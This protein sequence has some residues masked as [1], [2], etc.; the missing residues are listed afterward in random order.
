LFWVTLK[1]FSLIMNAWVFTRSDL[2]ANRGRPGFDVGCKAMQGIPR[3][4]DLVNPSG[5]LI[6]ANDDNYALA[7]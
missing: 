5:N 1:K 3:A 7:A 6:V 4:S 2:A